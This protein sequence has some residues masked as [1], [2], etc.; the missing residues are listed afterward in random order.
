MIEKSLHARLLSFPLGQSPAGGRLDTIKNQIHGHPTDLQMDYHELQLGKPSILFERD[1][2]PWEQVQGI[3]F[4]RR[5]YFENTQII[6]GG[7]LSTYFNNLS[8]DHPTYNI[9]NALAWRAT[10]GQNHYLFGF[11]LDVYSSLFLIAQRCMAQERDG[12][13][14]EVS[15]DRE[16]SPPPL[17][18]A[19]Q[20]PNPR[21]LHQRY[22]GNPITIRL[23]GITQ[24]RRLFIG[25][26]DIQGSNRP[27]VHAV[28]NLGE[29]A[30][31]WTTKTKPLPS[32]RWENKGE[33]S[34]G[35]NVGE[36]TQEALWVIERLQAG[37][38]ILV[39]CAAG[40]NRSATICCAVIILLEHVSAETALARVR[41]HHPWARPD[42]NHWLA[43]RWLAYTTNAPVYEGS[44]E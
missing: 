25:G 41:E 26:V 6:N 13:P 4:P 5:L 10:D 8:S 33:G 44:V 27:D 1:G 20:I 23:N 36:I 34:A 40:M 9:K 3:Y 22:G 42:S 11:I 16:W 38:R 15:F 19:R 24:H 29:D 30:S 39:H 43:L 32:D 18:P 12:T 31:R 37:Q 35:M 2:K 21:Q 28:L 7:E 14:R 17:A